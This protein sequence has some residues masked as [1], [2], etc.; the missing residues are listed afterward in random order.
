M[1]RL[2][3]QYIKDFNSDERLKKNLRSRLYDALKG[4]LK[5]GSAIKNLGCTIDELKTH[6]E[7]QFTKGMNWE[8]YGKWHIDHIKPLSKFNFND[9]KEF[10]EAVH[11]SNLQPLWAKDNLKKGN[12]Y[13][14]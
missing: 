14:K 8:N 2:S 11:Y 6:L 4:R 9:A 10:E 1:C 7:K 13:E 5:I 3:N 12:K